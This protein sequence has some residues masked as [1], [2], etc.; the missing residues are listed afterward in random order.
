MWF[1]LLCLHL[2]LSL[3]VVLKVLLFLFLFVHNVYQIIKAYI[4]ILGNISL[5]F[6]I[7]IVTKSKAII[8]KYIFVLDISESQF[9][10]LLFGIFLPIFCIIVIVVY[11]YNTI[12]IVLDFEGFVKP[13]FSVGGRS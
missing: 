1:L 2:K 7:Q 10:E 8:I 9:F 12:Y 11:T 5:K 13:I 4:I 6:S 3:L